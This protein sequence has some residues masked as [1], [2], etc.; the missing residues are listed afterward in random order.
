M[1]KKIE[2]VTGYKAFNK[3]MKCRDF[4]YKVG[5]TYTT[6]KPIELCETGFHFCQNPLD[7]L[8]YY[9]LVD[10]DANL[11]EF[12]RVE[13]TGEVRTGNDKSVTNKITIKSK[14]TLPAF[15]KASVEFAWEK[16]SENDAKDIDTGDYNQLATSGHSS[17]LAT[18]G[19]SSQ[20]ATSGHSS[21]LATSGR[22]NR[23]ATSGHSSQLATSGDYSRLAIKGK[24]SVGAAIGRNSSIK[25]VKGTWITLAEYNDKYEVSNVMS[26]QIDGKILKANVY[27]QLKDGKFVEA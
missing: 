11:T 19:D 18:S 13:S 4:Q 7:V 24:H 21:Q 22:Y 12:A 14:L 23:L 3:G 15:I 1:T 17:Q 27:Y 6:D 8:G 26:A 5:E 16:C 20:L 2:K 25:G 9:D 10:G